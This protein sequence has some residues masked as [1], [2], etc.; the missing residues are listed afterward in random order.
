MR[1]IRIQKQKVPRRRDRDEVLSLD[2]R[3]PDVLRV[4]T[5][6]RRRAA[7]LREAA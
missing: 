5:A 3:D 6:A 7:P 1:R 2:P 4:K